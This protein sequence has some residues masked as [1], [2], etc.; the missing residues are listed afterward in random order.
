MYYN[1]HTAKCRLFTKNF[2]PGE[3]LSLTERIGVI[4]NT[5]ILFLKKQADYLEVWNFC[6]THTQPL[7]R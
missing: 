5:V 3:V 6:V 4:F 1:G 2:S 7:A